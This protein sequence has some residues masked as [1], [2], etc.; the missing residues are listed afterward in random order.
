MMRSIIISVVLSILLAGHLFAAELSETEKGIFELEHIGMQIQSVENEMS[1]Y[2]AQEEKDSPNYNKGSSIKP[3]K[4]A[5]SDLNVIKEKL[6]AL[7]LPPEL[8]ELKAQFVGVIDRL[9]GIYSAVAKKTK[10]DQGKEFKAFWEMV[11][12]YNNNLKTKIN[13]AIN[14]PKDL[15]EFDLVAHEAKLFG[16]P[17]DAEMFQKADNLITK[18]KKYAEAT[19]ILNNLL[20]RYKDTPAEGSIITRIA[21]CAE[22]G[23]DEVFKMLGDPEYILKMLDG[24]IMKKS[25]SPNIQR[26]YLQWRTLKQTFENGLSN[27]SGIPNDKYIEALWGVKEGIET[28]IAAN[29]DDE[30]AK[31]QLLLLMDTP[32]IERW[33]SD[34]PYG[35]SV[36]ID[37]YNLWG[38]ENAP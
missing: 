16:V 11:D 31:L 32:L 30:W 9:A 37:H 12:T 34:Y 27:W 22:M 6:S 10:I 26:I 3:A 4:K 35:S 20:T 29:P 8:N 18:D 19:P 2:L 5:V 17:Q 1:L 13:S 24:F 33:R 7:S 38:L 21:D 14:V 25:Y 28:Y 23:G 36:A 15:K